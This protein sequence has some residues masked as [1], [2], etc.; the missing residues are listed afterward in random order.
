[1]DILSMDVDKVVAVSEIP[2]F[3]IEEFILFYYLSTF[4]ETIDRLK[5]KKKPPAKQ[6]AFSQAKA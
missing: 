1:M 6:T 2:W 3:L 4:L 5:S